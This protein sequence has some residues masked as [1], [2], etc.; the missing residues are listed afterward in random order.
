MP[1]I[2]KKQLEEFQALE[3]RMMVAEAVIAHY[4]P[5][6][7][8]AKEIDNV[9]FSREGDALY[10]PPKAD[11]SGETVVAGTDEVEEVEASEVVEVGSPGPESVEQVRAVARPSVRRSPIM[12]RSTNRAR[13]DIGGMGHKERSEYY[14][15]VMQNSKEWR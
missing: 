14:R 6:V 1:N 15:N 5:G 7:D 12:A 4:A 2:S 11:Q 9:Y 8:L 10:V 13:P 3:D